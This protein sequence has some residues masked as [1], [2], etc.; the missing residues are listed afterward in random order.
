MWNT[1]MRSLARKTRKQKFSNCFYKLFLI[2]GMI[3][4]LINII[5]HSSL[6]NDWD[7]NRKDHEESSF[8]AP[9]SASSKSSE[10]KRNIM[11]IA[12]YPKTE[13]RLL[14]IWSQLECF[15]VEYD[16]IIISAPDEDWSRDA[17]QNFTFQVMVHLPDV[18]KMLDVQY[19]VNDRYDAG[20]WCDSLSSLQN[21]T[22]YRSFHNFFL[23]NDS[24]LAL[25][26]SNDFLK[27]LKDQNASLISLNEWEDSDEYGYWVE[28]AVRLFSR[29]GIET[30]YNNLCKDLAFKFK[31]CKIKANELEKEKMRTWR[32]KICIVRSTEIQVSKFYNRSKVFGLYQG[33]VP[34]VT[35]GH[36]SWS[37]QYHYWKNVL[38]GNLKFPVMKVSDTYPLLS[39]AIE[40]QETESLRS[41]TSR[42]IP[43]IL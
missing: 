3:F 25:R 7:T 15:A 38:V 1:M 14:A 41:C 16:N 23:I 6:V 8:S 29:D 37:H 42:Y 35:E 21:N 30:Y 26:K 9:L 43:Y 27:T 19:Y 22:Q 11:I 10:K 24:L 20:L 39:T 28:S 18:Y 31:Y 17:L 2:C 32:Y 34:N 12:A 13:V 36:P 40:K 5:V 4:L 33:R